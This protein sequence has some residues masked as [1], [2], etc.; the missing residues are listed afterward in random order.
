MSPCASENIACGV[1]VPTP[2]FPFAR[3]VKNSAPVEDETVNGLS[4]PAP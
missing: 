4:P 3:I 2:M 1:E